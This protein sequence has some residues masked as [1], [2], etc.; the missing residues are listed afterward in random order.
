[1]ATAGCSVLACPTHTHTHANGVA[2]LCLVTYRW[3]LGVWFNVIRY[4][5]KVL[6]DLGR[7]EIPESHV[8]PLHKMLLGRDPLHC[9][10][11]F[12]RLA[13][14]QTRYGFEFFPAVMNK[15]RNKAISIGIGEAGVK[16]FDARN[17][18]RL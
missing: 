17:S 14:Q 3:W 6:L 9:E 15:D 8:H 12:I 10:H 13:S 2:L 7:S 4:M 16:V 18:V 11:E 1:M 5:G